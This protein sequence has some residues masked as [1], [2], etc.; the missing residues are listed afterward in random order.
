MTHDNEGGLAFGDSL[1]PA[2]DQTEWRMGSSLLRF[3]VDLVPMDSHRSERFDANLD[4]PK[5]SS[6]LTR[7]QNEPKVIP[8]LP[9]APDPNGSNPAQPCRVIYAI[10]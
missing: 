8:C 6:L 2:V 10:M 4:S 3:S 7:I 5:F 9:I 1:E